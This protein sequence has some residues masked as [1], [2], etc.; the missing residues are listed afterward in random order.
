[1]HGVTHIHVKEGRSKN[2]CR[3]LL[4]F[5]TGC[6]THCLTSFLYQSP[7]SSLSSVFDAISSA[8]VFVSED[9]NVH[10]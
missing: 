10:Y 6:F 4:M 1:M 8:N 3:F 9:F 2:L 7:S 5:L